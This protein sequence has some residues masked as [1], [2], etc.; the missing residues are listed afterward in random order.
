MEQCGGT[1]NLGKLQS[2]WF[3]KTE[4]E[5]GNPMLFSIYSH[6]HEPYLCRIRLFENNLS[7][8]HQ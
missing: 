8:E 1:W 7:Q 2:L 5:N 6:Y 3:L 4:A